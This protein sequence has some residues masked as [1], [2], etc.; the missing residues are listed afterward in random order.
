[1]T[2]LRDFAEDV[3]LG[4]LGRYTEL[5]RLA[6]CEWLE[7]HGIDPANVP[8]DSAFRYVKATNEWTC[9]Y[10]IRDSLGRI[11]LREDGRGMRTRPHTFQG[12]A[13]FPLGG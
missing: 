10:A 13:P 5:E 3:A 1:M 9:A 12:R 11:Q 4:L 7:L 6:L 8:I 2:D